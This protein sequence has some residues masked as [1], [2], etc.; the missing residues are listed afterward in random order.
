M[1]FYIQLTSN[2]ILSVINLILTVRKAIPNDMQENAMASINPR[3]TA[4]SQPLVDSM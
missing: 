1:T 2:I 4:Q 3:T